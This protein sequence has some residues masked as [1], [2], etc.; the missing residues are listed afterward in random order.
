MWTVKSP[1]VRVQG[2]GSCIKYQAVMV[3]MSSLYSILKMIITI[4]SSKYALESHQL[5]HFYDIDR[6]FLDYFVDLES[7]IE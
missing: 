7:S 2:P 6:S 4:I 1:S 3:K 5:V